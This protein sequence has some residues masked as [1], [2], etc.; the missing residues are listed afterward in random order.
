MVGSRKFTLS[1]KKFIFDIEIHRNLTLIRGDGATYKT[2]I[3]NMVADADIIGSG[4]HLS[5]YGTKVLALNDRDFGL[6]HLA[7]YKGMD[8]ILIFDEVSSCVKTNAFREAIEATGC[9]FILLTRRNC[10]CFGISTKEVYEFAYDDSLN[11]NKRTIFMKQ[12]YPDTTFGLLGGQ[13]T[14]ITE[15]SN[16]G[17]QFFSSVYKNNTVIS[18][19]GKSNIYSAITKNANS[20]VIV[21]GAAFGFEIEDTLLVLS[22]YNCYLIALESFEYCILKSGIFAN[23]LT[24]DVDNP[25]VDSTEYLTW[26]RYY[27]DLLQR[28]SANTQLAYNKLNLN[29]AYCTP[30]N[31]IKILNVYKLP[32]TLT[33]SKDTAIKYTQ[34]F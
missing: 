19:H 34:I 10:S 2:L 13:H 7:R 32:A 16:A 30:S 15:D 24:V 33:S 3:W 31:M 4:I 6:D 28:I 23:K 5:S 20:I 8:A 17:R 9:Y 14:V 26:E 1:S 11:F 22:K 25:E 27:T 21:D 12:L 29:K 18:A